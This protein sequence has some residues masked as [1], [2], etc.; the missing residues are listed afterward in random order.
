MNKRQRKQAYPTT[1]LVE[2]FHPE[3]DTSSPSH[4]ADKSE[5]TDEEYS[6]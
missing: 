4:G 5:G 1:M 2:Q 3:P 6:N